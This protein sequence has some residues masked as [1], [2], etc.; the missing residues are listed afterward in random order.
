M[1]A[2]QVSRATNSRER[3]P[4]ACLVLLKIPP[5][6]STPRVSIPIE[7][8]RLLTLSAS[9]PVVEV[10]PPSLVPVSPSEMLD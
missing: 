10:W 9:P 5:M 3:T 1:T 7:S 4:E 2:S 6:P 8:K